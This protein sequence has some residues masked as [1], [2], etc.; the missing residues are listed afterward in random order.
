MG[1]LVVVGRAHASDGPTGMHVVACTC[2]F[3]QLYGSLEDCRMVAGAHWAEYDGGRTQGSYE[4][5]EG[6]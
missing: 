2:G 4:K 5:R 6:V 3:W 1:H